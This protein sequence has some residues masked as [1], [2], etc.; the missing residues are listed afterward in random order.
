MVTMH[1]GGIRGQVAIE[2]GRVARSR[3][4]G[5]DAAVRTGRSSAGD[6]PARSSVHR[7]TRRDAP[8][9]FHL[10]YGALCLDFAN[11]VSWRGSGNPVDRLPVYEELIRF[12]EQSKL[13]TEDDARRLR[14]EA[15]R[16]PETAG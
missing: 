7:S 16:H 9:I 6:R 10:G 14:R 13:L 4:P 2:R 5:R 15:A 11:T 12:G 8:W 1:P 3:G